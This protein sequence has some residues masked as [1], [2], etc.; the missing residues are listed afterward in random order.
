MK[1][2]KKLALSTAVSS[3]FA[4]GFVGCG[5]GSSAG[6]SSNNIGGT[7][8]VGA[9]LYAQ[10]EVLDTPTCTTFTSTS[11]SNGVWTSGDLSGTAGPYL[12]KVSS[13]VGFN[14][15]SYVDTNTSRV[16]N[17]TPLTYFVTDSAA[18]TIAGRSIA[19][20]Y[21]SCNNGNFT[22]LG[23]F[24]DFE[25]GISNSLNTLNT[26]LRNANYTNDDQVEFNHFND[27]F[28]AD[29]TGYDALLDEIDMSMHNNDTLLR[30]NG[31]ILETSDDNIT[32]E[33]TQ[34]ITSSVVDSS[35]N[36]LSGVTV[37]IK[38]DDLNQTIV[39]TL[40]T[41]NSGI[42]TKNDLDQYRDYIITFEKDGYTSTS[43]RYNTFTTTNPNR[44]VLFT[45]DETLES[46]SVSPSISII[47]SRNGDTVTDVSVSIRR[48]LNNRLGEVIQSF[49]TAD[50]S[51]LSLTPG[52]YT[53]AL[54]KNGFEQEFVN[55][56]ITP[57]TTDLNMDML[58]INQNSTLNEG[59]FATI[60]LR[61]GLNPEDVDSHTLL[62]IDNNNIDVFYNNPQ[63]GA[64]PADRNNPCATS[65]VIASLDLDDV[66]SYGPETTTICDGSKG[67]FE[68]K[69]HHYYGMSDIGQSPTSVELITRDGSRYEFNAPTS[70]F[71]GNDNDVWNVFSL[72]E[73][74]NVTTINT[75]TNNGNDLD[76]FTLNSS[77]IENKSFRTT[78]KDNNGYVDFIFNENGIGVETGYYSNNT[79]EYTET[80]NWVIQNNILVKTLSDNTVETILFSSQPM[81]G[82][83]VRIINSSMSSEAD[84]ENSQAI[85]S[86]YSDLP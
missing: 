63:F 54:T 66:E 53:F 67:P 61:W 24:N 22:G 48:G 29:Q 32:S 35:N 9:G 3:V 39:E 82:S 74:Q 72:D 20:M 14:M 51:T 27:S 10:V 26:Q 68:F 73:N 56:V 21:A 57:N 85:I 47:N 7:V 19:D 11:S 30:I 64:I 76:N 8:A 33:T 4:I 75:I 16:A 58:S 12:I 49:N 65:G 25:T 28:D 15:Y 31:Q 6:S 60:I 43:I 59:A 62:S 46:N 36:P 13:S 5:G 45:A 55:K 52:A 2:F 18:R 44:V 38:I 17:V 1:K 81:N 83:T 78:H 80:F 79:V 50:N 37:T 34:T 77:M 23:N 84:F 40:T 41:D 70:G 42:Y 86:N 71:Q 69:V